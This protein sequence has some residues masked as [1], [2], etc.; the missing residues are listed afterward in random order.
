[1]KTDAGLL[2]VLAAFAIALVL[3]YSKWDGSPTHGMVTY[4]YVTT[5][6]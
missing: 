4:T 6:L 5:T 2:F 1:M 3:M